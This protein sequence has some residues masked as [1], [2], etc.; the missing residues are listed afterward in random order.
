MENY[1]NNIR[2]YFTRNLTLPSQRMSLD[3]IKLT[4]LRSI[5]RLI[6]HQINEIILSNCI[7]SEV[8]MWTKYYFHCTSRVK[9]TFNLRK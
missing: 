7:L 9:S 4:S 6:I 8:S 2:K 1:T 3:Q 5:D